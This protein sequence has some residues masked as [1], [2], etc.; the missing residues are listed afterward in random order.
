MPECSIQVRTLIAE[1]YVDIPARAV[2]K[3]FDYKVPDSLEQFIRPGMRVTVPFGRVK[4]LG[5][6]TA[7]KNHTDFTKLRN[8]DQVIDHIPVLTDELLDLG[9]WIADTTLC[10]TITAYQAMLPAVMKADYGKV[11]QLENTEK[12]KDVHPDLV[13]FYSS[14]DSIKWED[15]VRSHPEKLNEINRAL[16]D[17]TLS[18]HQQIHNQARVKKIITVTPAVSLETLEEAAKSLNRRYK[19]QREVLDFFIHHPADSH[20]LA[21]LVNRYGLSREA[22]SH[23]IKKG[24]L[25]K[26]KQEYFRDPYREL[27]QVRTQALT[28][29]KEQHAALKP[30]LHAIESDEDRVF[31]CHGVT[32]SGKTEIYLQAIQRVIDL[33]KEAIVLVPE[34]SLTPQMVHRFKGRFG[35]LVAVMHSGLS[36]G[37]K[38]DEWRKIREGRVKV[39]VGARSAVFAPFSRLGLII[40]D[41]E[42]ES[43]YKQEDSP[44]YHARDVA[45]YRSRYNRCPVVLGSATPSLESYAR[46]KKNVYS[47]LLLKERFNHHPLPPVKIVDMREE[48]RDGNRS[49]FSTALFNLI[50]DRIKKKEQTVLFLNRR[51]YSTFVMCRSCGEVLRC[52]HCDISLTYHRTEQLLKCHYCGYAQQIP[53]TCP[54]CGSDSMRYF[55]TGTQK[56]EAE[57]NRLIPEARI[58]RMDVDTTR[59]KGGHERLLRRFGEGKADILLGTQMIAKGLDFPEVTL[60]GVLAADSMLYLPDFRASERTFQLLTQVSGRAGRHDLPGSVIIQSYDPDHYAVVDAASHD[61]ETFYQQEMQIRYRH[62]YPPF[63]YLVL[64][65]ITHTDPGQA[66][67]AAGRIAEILKRNLSS[68]AQIFGP[69]VPAIA[70]IKDRYR[71]QCMVKYK[72]EPELLPVLRKIIG[73]FQEPGKNSLQ[74]VVDINPVV[75]M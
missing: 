60:V 34:I 51:G 55:G 22:I 71:Y 45:I 49:M 42:H 29:T 14:G 39:A 21:D 20:V 59:Q 27:N 30:I 17:G 35:D 54:A 6:V 26:E 47:L 72:K 38:Y 10:M 5:F 2:D 24:V 18:L 48:M 1:V 12:L 50:K 44:R 15:A 40:I 74:L 53:Q 65:R 19:R 46:A 70:R 73:H 36:R 63:Y 69:V 66:S 33:G 28:L 8:I 7:L 75:F 68:S 41:E 64:I 4:R 23:F 56:V 57:L 25:R 9:R 32:G 52:P 62:G 67:V 11:I 31:L 43:S 3:P 61:Y 13:P 16:S 58:I 37:E